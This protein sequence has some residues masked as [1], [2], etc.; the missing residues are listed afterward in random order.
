MVCRNPDLAA[1][2]WPQARRTARRRRRRSHPHSDSRAPRSI[3]GRRR[4]LA[5]RRR[6]DQPTQ[7]G[8]AFCSRHLGYELWLPART[9]RS[10]PRR[11]LQMAS[12]SCAPVCLRRASTTRRRCAA[13]NHSPQE[14]ACI[15]TVDLQVR[16]VYHWL[17]DRVRAHVF[18][19]M[20]AY[21]LEWHMRQRPAPDAV[22]RYRQAGCRSTAHLRGGTGATPARR[23]HQAD[24][25]PDPGCGHGVQP[26]SPLADLATLA[27][28]TVT[29]AIT[30]NHP[31][32]VLTRPTSIQHKVFALLGITCSQ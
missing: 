30:L 12:M 7:D 3:T 8:Q 11:R 18:L 21:H 24:H 13:T 25:R 1:Q 26:G 2:R 16:P 17:A 5:G 22:R 4:D 6:S 32:T 10:L 28:N 20:L 23:R 31:I 9:L 27:R 29:T 15:K 19:C 14:R